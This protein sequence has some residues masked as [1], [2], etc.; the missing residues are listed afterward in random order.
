MPRRSRSA[1]IARSARK[2]MR[3]HIADLAR[4]A[5]TLVCAYPNAGLP[6]EFGLYDE[7]PNPWRR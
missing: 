7:S 3:A 6:N 1:S 2:E 5:D 4:V